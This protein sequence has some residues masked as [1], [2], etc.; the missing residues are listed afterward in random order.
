[1]AGVPI[2]LVRGEPLFPV[3]FCYY[4]GIIIDKSINC[5]NA[6][7]KSHWIADIFTKDFEFLFSE[8]QSFG[9]SLHYSLLDVRAFDW[10]GRN[11]ID[12]PNISIAPR[13]TALVEL[14]AFDSMEQYLTMISKDRRLD[15]GRAKREK[16]E[17]RSSKSTQNF[18]NLLQHT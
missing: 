1:M 6:V 4:Q 7:R 11:K 18:I 5:L 13:Y 8:Y 10:I 15:L 14:S 2:I 3:P 9:L 12:R 17:W 16:L